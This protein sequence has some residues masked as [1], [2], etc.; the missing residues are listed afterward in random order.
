MAR[1]FGLF[2]ALLTTWLLLS[3]VYKPLIIGFGV[4]SCAFSVWVARWLGVVDRE[5][6][7]LGMLPRAI[8]YWFWLS[9]E[10]VKSNIDVFKRVW[11]LAPIDPA[12]KVVPTSQRTDLGRVLYAQSITLT[13]GTVSVDIEDGRIVAHA[14]HASALDALDEGDMDRRCTALEGPA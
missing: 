9:V 1:A 4:L 7:P 11:G 12:W 14:L 13:P 6:A 8:R 5:G 2:L 3:G 10:I